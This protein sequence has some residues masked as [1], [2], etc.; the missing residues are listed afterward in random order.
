M[1]SPFPG[2]DPYLEHPDFWSE[3]HNRLIVAIAIA[4]APSLRPKYHVV[5]DKRTYLGD[6]D[7]SLL[8]GVPD[9]TVFTQR[10]TPDRPLS[11]ATLAD[12]E[13]IKVAVPLIET[14]QESYLEIRETGKNYAVTVLEIL[15]PKN[16]RSGA[17]RVAY[18]SKRSQVLAS[19]TNL[20]EIDLL[21]SGKPMQIVGNPPKTD[22][23]I[24]I[25]RGD[26]RPISDLYAFSLRDAIPSFPLPLARGDLEPIVD[27]Q[28]LVNEIYEQA[29]FDTRIDYNQSCVPPLSE[30]DAV[31]ANSLLQEKGFIAS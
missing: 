24:L 14:V 27:L 10:S 29:G 18:E 30:A 28:H 15:S 4:L 8:V 12:R 22:Y 13:P 3:L 1:P 5:I 2:V 23:R 9:V 31:W 21:R 6:A 17:G 11:V 16:K 20:V 19:I 25:S 26:R 7:D